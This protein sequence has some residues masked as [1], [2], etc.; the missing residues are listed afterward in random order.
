MGS[1]TMVTKMMRGCPV[2]EWD[3]DDARRHRPYGPLNKD[4]CPLKG[5][6]EG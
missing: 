3:E 4:A 1:E 6:G 2:G 5:Q